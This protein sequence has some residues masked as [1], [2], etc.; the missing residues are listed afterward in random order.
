MTSPIQRYTN[1]ESFLLY[2]KC[3]VD[4]IKINLFIN[5]SRESER[6]SFVRYWCAF[7]YLATQVHQ[8]FCTIFIK[9]R[10]QFILQVKK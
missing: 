4:T 8:L 7:I 6:S 10:F 9:K 3:D 1:A 2:I 5:E